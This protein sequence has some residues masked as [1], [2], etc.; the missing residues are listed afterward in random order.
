MPETI[1]GWHTTERWRAESILQEGFRPP[2]GPKVF[3][4]GVYVAL[5]EATRDLYLEHKGDTTLVVEATVENPLEVDLQRHHHYGVESERYAVWRALAGRSLDEVPEVWPNW[6]E[7]TEKLR[8]QGHDAI[9]AT[10]DPHPSY[11]GPG[12]NQLV[13]LDPSKVRPLYILQDEAV[14]A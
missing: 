12:G 7:L 10:N 14:A 4:A 13:V 1:T 11:W 3:G 2:P 8:A 9:L 6:T 5:D